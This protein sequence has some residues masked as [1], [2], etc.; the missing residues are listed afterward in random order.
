MKDRREFDESG[1]CI[2]CYQ[3]CTNVVLDSTSKKEKKTP[4]GYFFTGSFIV[5]LKKKL[6][7]FLNVRKKC[8]VK[9]STHPEGHKS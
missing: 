7:R 2:L 9:Q 1:K 8:D 3:R 6:I 4:N 5:V